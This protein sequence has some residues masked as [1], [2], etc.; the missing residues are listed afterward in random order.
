MPPPART[1]LAAT[2]PLMIIGLVSALRA[3]PNV[4][5]VDAAS[6]FAGGMAFGA[7]LFGLIQA[8]RRSSR[9]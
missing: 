9:V 4:R 3:L 6:L 7:G 8:M 1:I 2:I 5:A